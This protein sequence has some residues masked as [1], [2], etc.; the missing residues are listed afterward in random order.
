MTPDDEGRARVDAV[1]R[2]NG[3]KPRARQNVVLEFG[4]FASLLG[5]DKVCV[6]TRG[7]LELPSDMLGIVPIDYGE[8]GAW[9]TRLAQ[10]LRQAK[11]EVDAERV[12][13]ALAPGRSPRSAHALPAVR[14]LRPRRPPPAVRALPARQHPAAGPEPDH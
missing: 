9:K 2:K 7:E 4:L 3:L 10:E 8:A 14:T 11:L 12:I 13:A 5:R 6:I 1:R